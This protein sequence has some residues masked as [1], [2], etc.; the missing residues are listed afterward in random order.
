MQ[1]SFITLRRNSLCT[2]HHQNASEFSKP[3]LS[4]EYLYG[5]YIISTGEGHSVTHLC[6]KKI[7]A[8]SVL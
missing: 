7:S 5:L 3:S 2:S 8:Y 4:Y 6:T 1:A